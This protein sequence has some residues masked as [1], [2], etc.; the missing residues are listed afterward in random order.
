MSLGRRAEG[1]GEHLSLA[2]AAIDDETA[3]RADAGASIV[4]L[5][6]GSGLN[7]ATRGRS[8]PVCIEQPL[9]KHRW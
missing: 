5:S 3:V 4:T 7:I 8:A 6:R 1:C 2:V 9:P